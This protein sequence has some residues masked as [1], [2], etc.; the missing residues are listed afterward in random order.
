MR[1]REIGLLTMGFPSFCF[2]RML[3]NIDNICRLSSTTADYSKVYFS[4]STVEV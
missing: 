4:E 3:K 2:L 1:V